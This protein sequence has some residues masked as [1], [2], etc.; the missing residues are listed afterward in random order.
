M[1]ALFKARSQPGW[2]CCCG[3]EASRQ[4]SL[5]APANANSDSNSDECKSSCEFV[6][7]FTAALSCLSRYGLTFQ[8]RGVFIYL[9]CIAFFV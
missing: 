2:M 4:A 3:A 5:K 9:F 1:D 7:L 6:M 8:L